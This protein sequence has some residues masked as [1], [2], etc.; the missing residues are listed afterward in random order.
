MTSPLDHFRRVSLILQ[1]LGKQLAGLAGIIRAGERAIT[2]VHERP[3][4]FLFNLCNPLMKRGY[5]SCSC[6]FGG[7]NQPTMG[8]TPIGTGMRVDRV[9][10]IESGEG[11]PV[12]RRVEV[13]DLS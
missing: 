5:L 9:P 13:F 1:T 4:L 12:D 3:L 2:E 11:A 7:D 10:I 6:L 8:N